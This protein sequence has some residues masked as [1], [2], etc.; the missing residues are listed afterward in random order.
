MCRGQPYRGF[1]FGSTEGFNLKRVSMA[2]FTKV[3]N[4]YRESMYMV[5]QELE[6]LCTCLLIQVFIHYAVV[7]LIDGCKS[8]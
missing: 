7:L 5:M 4:G 1:M 8:S 2:G 3:I 6:V